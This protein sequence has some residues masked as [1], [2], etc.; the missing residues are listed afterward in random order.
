MSQQTVLR[1]WNEEIRK[2]MTHLSKPQSKALAAFSV[3]IAKE[4]GCGLSAA[5]KKLSFAENPAAV[6]RGIQRF[7]AS[8]GIDHAESC[9]AAAKWVIGSLPEDKPDVLVVNETGLKDRLKAMVAAVAFAGR[10]IPVAWRRCPQV[11]D[12]TG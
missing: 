10:A 11:A 1:L 6:E 7:I 5:D 9:R 2:R 8:D 4:E 3:R 12:G